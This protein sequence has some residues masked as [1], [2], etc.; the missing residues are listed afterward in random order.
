[1]R[2]AKTL[3]IAITLAAASPLAQASLSSDAHAFKDNVKA[4]GKQGGHAVRDATFAIGRGAKAAGHA[5][6]DA[7]KQGFHATKRAIKGH[8]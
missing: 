1:M 3:M 6:A 7:T 4:A 8:D 5:V 2:K